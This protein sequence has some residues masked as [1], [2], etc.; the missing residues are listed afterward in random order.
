MG[1][2]LVKRPESTSKQ[3]SEYTHAWGECAALTQRERI[4]GPEQIWSRAFI[5][6]GVEYSLLA[7]LKQ[8]FM[9]FLF[10]LIKGFLNRRH[11]PSWACLVW[12]SFLWSIARIGLWPSF[13]ITG[14]VGRFLPCCG[15]PVW[16][17]FVLLPSVPKESPQGQ[18]KPQC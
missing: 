10:N 14:P 18:A 2:N 8:G 7:G 1:N 12:S 5:N 4:R 17:S 6:Q 11:S 3:F 9:P 16:S 13:L 15:T